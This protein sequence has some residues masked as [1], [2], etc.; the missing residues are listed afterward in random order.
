MDNQEENNI[1]S[2]PQNNQMT[3]K[4]R[5]EQE[6]HEAS[7]NVAH[8][9]GKGAAT[10]FGKGVGGKLYDVAS[11]TEAGQ[12]IESA[13]GKAAETAPMSKPIF[14][15]LNNSGALDAANK[16]IDTAG[17]SQGGA[18]PQ[19]NPNMLKGMQA[20]TATP[21]QKNNINTINRGHNLVEPPVDEEVAEQQAKQLEEQQ[22]AYEQAAQEQEAQEQKQ[23][24]EEEEQKK[25]AKGKLLGFI[26]LNN[27]KAMFL[28]SFLGILAF[29]IFYFV[30]IDIADMDLVGTRISSYSEA[31]EIG[32]YCNQI[33]LIKEHDEFTGPTVSNI[34]DVNLEETFIL[35]KK[36]EKRWSYQTYDLET[37]VKGVVQAEA[38]DVDDAKTFEVASIAARTYALQ[39]TSKKCYTWDNTN[40]KSQYKNPQ[41]FTDEK[42]GDKIASAA[43]ITTGIVITYDNSLV[44]MDNGNY[45]DYFCHIGKVEEKEKHT[46]YKMLQENEEERLF[47]PIDWVEENV[48]S[49]DYNRSG[50]YDNACQQEGM[51]LFG[52]KYLLNKKA[53]AYT[54]FRILMYYYGY[55]ISFKKVHTLIANGCYYWPVGSADST[56]NM[57]TGMPISTRI[58]SY[59]GKRNAPTAGASSNHGAIDIGVARN[60]NIIAA[61]SGTVKSVVSGCIEGDKRC[62]GGYGNYVQIDHGNG[63]LTIYAHL[64]RPTVTKGQSVVQGQ[65]IGLSGSTGVSTGPHLHFE[66]RLNGT[67]VDPLNYV[68]PSDPRPTNC[69]LY[70][71]S[72]S[73]TGTYSGKGSQE[74]ID[75]I[76][77]YAIQDMHS[78]GI[79]A[80]ITIAQA[81]LESNW[82]KSGLAANYN[83]YFGI[84]ASSSWSG[85]TTTM[86]TTECNGNNC[87]RTS[88]SWRVY[89][90]PLQ[91]IQDHSRLLQNRRYS[92]VVGEKDY[93]TA[94]TIIKNGGYATD[95][96]YVNKIISIIESNNLTK[97]DQ[98]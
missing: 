79:L 85:A 82:G 94:I 39:I 54:T 47:L 60:S 51:S 76:A 93:R 68:S 20:K 69:M 96:N 61:S 41:N 8:T 32:G 89:E 58:T 95:P 83:N 97:Y 64:T 42:V 40:K 10:Y 71:P 46:M 63:I 62:G 4:E 92:G 1:N 55:D 44:N 23:K 81:I 90:T 72:G 84:K 49:G 3:E 22:E 88:A 65:I 87:Y 31:E 11:Q 5:K 53:D 56:S 48:P 28:I 17:A 19:S 80:S 75:Y 26:L 50:K 18:T 27:P 43:N 24:E 98:M 33:I 59:F 16:V 38:K 9:V 2:Q 73:I 12:K 30:Y 25:K 78:S 29:V 52:A 86:Q 7:K 37:Y 67:K 34:D 36:T 13:V 66:V 35:N 77:K 45:Y 74:F 70:T 21:V 15:A 57:A 14:R 6:T 91:S